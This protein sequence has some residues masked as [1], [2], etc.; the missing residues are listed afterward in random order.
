MM[1]SRVG[2]PNSK[3]RAEINGEKRSRDASNDVH[4]KRV[5][6]L[7]MEVE[8]QNS[9][10]ISFWI[11]SEVHVWR[12]GMYLSTIPTLIPTFYLVEVEILFWRIPTFQKRIPA[13]S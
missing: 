7:V 13:F 4:T 1:V 8:Y 12:I 10:R 5:S 11:N 6:T 9:T 2:G 3:K